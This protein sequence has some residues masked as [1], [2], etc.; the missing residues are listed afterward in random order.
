M[1]YKTYAGDIPPTLA[2]IRY[3]ATLSKR[4][5]MS[6]PTVYSKGEAGRMIRELQAEMKFRD[7]VKRNMLA[8]RAY[9]VLAKEGWRLHY[10]NI[11]TAINTAC[12]GLNVSQSRVLAALKAR[13]DLFK[14]LDVGIF[15]IANK[16][17]GTTQPTI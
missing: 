6:E 15:Y 10:L 7:S 12:P 1:T 3:I 11:T 8:R 16:E 2:Q 17:E 13:P 4:L 5:G 14:Q 9:N